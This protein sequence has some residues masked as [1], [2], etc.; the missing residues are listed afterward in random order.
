M[1][2]G[3][4]FWPW[5]GSAVFPVTGFGPHSDSGFS[6]GAFRGA[7]GQSMRSTCS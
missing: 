3:S 5:I 7:S 1:R 6:L 2:L 4:D